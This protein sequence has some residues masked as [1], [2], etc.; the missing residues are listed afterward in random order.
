MN[1]NNGSNVDCNHLLLIQNDS[2]SWIIS[3]PSSSSI[4]TTTIHEKNWF[5]F[6]IKVILQLLILCFICFALYI[7]CTAPQHEQQQQQLQHRQ[8]DDDNYEQQQQQLSKDS[9]LERIK[10]NNY[11]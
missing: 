6:R 8:S 2:A 4:N 3:T 5:D 9:S 10:S 7:L 1:N 11:C